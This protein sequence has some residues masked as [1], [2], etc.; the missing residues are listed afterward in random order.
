MN[1]AIATNFYT[2]CI[3]FKWMLTIFSS[4]HFLPIT[5]LL[6]MSA[7]QQVFLW[8]IMGWWK[9]N[10]ALGNL[11]FLHAWQHN[12]LHGWMGAQHSSGGGGSQHWLCRGGT[13]GGANFGWC[14]VEHF[15]HCMHPAVALMVTQGPMRRILQTL[16]SY[17][18]VTESCSMLLGAT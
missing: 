11:R 12:L 6:T 10:S 15:P 18:W 13:S 4:N 1:M 9:G 3:N 2:N 17:A 7:T 14:A 5:Q 16:A 8:A